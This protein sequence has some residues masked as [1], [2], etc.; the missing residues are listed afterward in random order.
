MAGIGG[1]RTKEPCVFL[2]SFKTVTACHVT[3]RHC[4]TV[5]SLYA[6][7]WYFKS[8]Q[9]VSKMRV[10]RHT[11]GP[12]GYQ[13]RN[14]RKKLHNLDPA[15]FLALNK[16]DCATRIFETSSLKPVSV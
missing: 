7:S 16:R 1:R 13:I 4:M 11:R 6:T 2:S 15:C 3:I 14:S 9:G 10:H 12:F 5:M 8:L